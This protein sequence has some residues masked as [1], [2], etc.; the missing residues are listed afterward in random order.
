MSST[1]VHSENTTETRD[2]PTMDMKLFHHAGTEG[3]AAGPAPE[4]G[5][6]CSWVSFSDPDEARTGQ[7]DP[8][9]PS[10]YAEYMVREQA[11]E[12]LPR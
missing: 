10:W 5:S 1:D 4:R 8:D 7:E 3:R 11:G 6:Y 12:E 2:T 9:W